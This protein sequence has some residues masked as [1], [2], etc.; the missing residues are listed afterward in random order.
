MKK[1][2]LMLLSML[3][4]NGAS[5]YAAPLPTDFKERIS[6]VNRLCGSMP[7]GLIISLVL[8]FIAVDAAVIY[9]IVKGKKSEK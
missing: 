9:Y 7:S 1:R 3:M 2:I 8:L 5:A 6:L 4:L